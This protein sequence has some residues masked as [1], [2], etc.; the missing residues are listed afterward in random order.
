MPTHPKVTLVTCKA[1][2]T[3]F[4]GEEGLPDELAARGCDPQIKVWNDPDV[5]WS[6][7]GMV[8]VRSVSDYAQDRRAFLEWTRSLR[9]VQNS[10]DVLDWNSDKHYLKELAA[11]GM[12]TIPTN[13]LEPAQNLSKHQI[14]TRFPAFGEF[15]VKPAVSSGVRD[16]GRYTTVDTRQRQAAMRQ[17][18]GLLGEGRSVMIQ[19]YVEEIDLHGEIS[20]VFFNGLVSHAVEKRAALHPSSITDPTVH[21]AVVTAEPADSVAWKWGEEIRRVL[22]DYVRERNGHDDLLLFNRVDLVPDGQGSFMVMEVS[23]VDADLYLGTTP[24]ALGNFA[25]AISARAHW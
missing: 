9:R 20:L 1:Q 23:L 12:P 14:H 16:I 4:H 25:D 18:Q 17:V 24:R 10:C 5:D 11:L 15:V 21:E 8:V 22:H 3:L 19:R 2:P 6:E 13:W 7:A